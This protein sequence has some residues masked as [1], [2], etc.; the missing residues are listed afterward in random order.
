MHTCRTRLA[1]PRVVEDVISEKDPVSMLKEDNVDRSIM[2]NDMHVKD[3]QV[4]THNVVIDSDSDDDW[5][6]TP[7]PPS[8]QLHESENENLPTELVTED[9]LSAQLEQIEVMRNDITQ[10]EIAVDPVVQPSTSNQ[11]NEQEVNLAGDS[12]INQLPVICE[13]EEEDCVTPSDPLSQFRCDDIIQI[14]TLQHPDPYF[15][16]LESL[17]GKRKGKYKNSWNVQEIIVL[18]ILIEM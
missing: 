1:K 13:E 10:E 8:Q 5:Y 16:K 6:P 2:K 11:N 14:T 17:S 3:N 4:D 18:L 7:D 9:T 15:V 12:G